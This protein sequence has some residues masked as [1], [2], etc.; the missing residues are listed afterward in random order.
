MLKMHKTFQQLTAAKIKTQMNETQ[1]SMV[2]NPDESFC[3]ETEDK[4]NPGQFVWF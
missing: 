2:L 3:F 4:W 1:F